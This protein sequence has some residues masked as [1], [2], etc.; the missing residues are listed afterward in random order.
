M[1][2]RL[3]ELRSGIFWSA[4]S[5]DRTL[6]VILGRP[7]TLRDE[8]CDIEYPGKDQS[9]EILRSKQSPMQEPQRKRICLSQQPYPYLPAVYSFRFDRTTAEIKLMIY[10][11]ARS[12][13][14]FPWPTNLGKWQEQ[15]L[16]V[17]TELLE[18]AR[19]NLKWRG[20]AGRRST[21]DGALPLIELKYHQ[22]VMLL[23]RPSPAFPQPSSSTLTACYK[24]AVE[25]IRIQ[26]E[27]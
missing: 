13:A 2:S 24:S 3:P 17:C 5:L 7:L 12:P 22:C 20:R 23:Y 14:R 1:D 25:T 4:Y 8:A 6:S 15:T 26:S 19:Q 9:E 16:Q 11:V 27:L 21:L 10:R 18:Q